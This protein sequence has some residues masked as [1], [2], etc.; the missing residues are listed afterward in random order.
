MEFIGIKIIFG[1]EKLLI[2]QN[3]P[4]LLKSVKFKV[5]KDVMQENFKEQFLNWKRNNLDI[6]VSCKG[7]QA[8]GAGT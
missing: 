6:N 3:L 2:R 7:R 4:R 8:M 1:R 5:S